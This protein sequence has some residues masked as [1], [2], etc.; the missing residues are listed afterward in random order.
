MKTLRILIPAAI[1]LILLAVLLQ[2]LTVQ[3]AHSGEI[4]Y[5]NKAAAGNNDGSSWA[6]AFTSLQD[7]LAHAAPNDWIWVAAGVYYPD[8]GAGQVD[9]DP[10]AAFVLKSKVN[11]VGGF[12]G[13]ETTITQRDP[14]V[15]I[16]VLSGDIDQNDTTDANGV[17]TDTANI[18]GRNAYHVVTSSNVELNTG[19]DGFIITAGQADG[20]FP[21]AVGGGMYIDQGRPYLSN[22]IFSGNT[23]SQGGGIYNNNASQLSLYNVTFSSNTAVTDGGGMRSDGSNLEMF[24]VTFSGN[25]AGRNGGGMLNWSS[26]ATL[27][28]V[29]FTANSASGSGGGLSNINSS[30]LILTGTLFSANSAGLNGG[31]IAND[32][33]SLT[34]TNTRLTANSASGGGG[35]GLFNRLAN[36]ILTN[37][38]ISANTGLAGGGMHNLASSPALTNVVFLN[39]S[40][41]I[42]G[43]GLSNESGSAP[44]LTNVTFSANSSTSYGGGIFNDDS[45]PVLTNVTIFSSTG[46][47]GGGMYNQNVSSPVLTNTIITNSTGGD[48][49]ND[50]NSSIATGSANNLIED[51]TSACGLTNGTNGNIIGSDPQLG[52]LTDFGGPGRQ[53]FPLL[54]GSPAINAGSANNCPATD[55]RGVSR[56]QGAGCD[57]GAYELIPLQIAQS[58]SH[59]AASVGQTITFTIVVSNAALTVT[60]GL[61]SGALPAGLN[62]LGPVTLEPAGAGVTGASPNLAADLTLGAGQQVTVTFPVTVSFGLTNGAQLTYTAAISSAQAA[63]TDS[64]AVAIVVNSNTLYLPMVIRP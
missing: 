7:A 2:G 18:T 15:N 24:D 22:V 46:S 41:N 34:I 60:D 42:F 57:I 37:V 40:A 6:D 33:S 59:P 47:S 20:T 8:E 43:G 50:A 31:G 12:A 58:V 53:V 49:V 27:E 28:A 17:V 4:I 5:V 13:T 61:I 26:Q 56:P 62:F 23:A 51:S 32:S 10:A 14:A 52:A 45:A 38:V 11:I 55:Q 64:S 9:D 30:S 29:T 1:A 3:A 39:N 25:S 16:T 21:D 35:G 19:L 54:P 48:C 36:P 63:F 44:A